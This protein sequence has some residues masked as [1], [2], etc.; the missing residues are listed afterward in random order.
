MT[1]EDNGKKFICSDGSDIDS[2]VIKV[3]DYEPLLFED[4]INGTVRAISGCVSQE[5][6]VSFKWIKMSVSSDTE[7]EIIPTIHDNY[8]RSCSNDFDC[9]Y[10]QQVQYTE[11]ISAKS[12]DNG[13]YFLKVLAVYGNKS[14]ESCNTA[15]KYMIEENDNE[16]F[17]IAKEIGL[18]VAGLLGVKCI[19]LCIGYCMWKCWKQK[20]KGKGKLTSQMHVQEDSS[21]RERLV[22][23]SDTATQPMNLQQKK[24]RMKLPE[25]PEELR[26]AT[27]YHKYEKH[28][29]QGR[30]TFNERNFHNRRTTRKEPSRTPNRAAPTDK[31][32]NH[33]NVKGKKPQQMKEPWRI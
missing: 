14:K 23:R 7:E 9:G 15:Y 32:G 33:R 4:T 8:T 17:N 16:R 25:E 3:T 18:A 28:D 6:E 19:L 1:K 24:S 26:E 5:T 20:R 29:Q 27:N 11:M 13:K 21:Q 30:E 2:E 22:E 12:S 31:T 10:D